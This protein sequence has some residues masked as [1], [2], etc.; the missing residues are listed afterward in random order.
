MKK[1]SFCCNAPLVDGVQ[2][3][4]CGADGRMTSSGIT[5]AKI[6][7]LV[8]QFEDFKEGEF[9]SLNEIIRFSS[10]NYDELGFQF[11]WV[12]DAGL[13]A[14]AFGNSSD[15]LKSGAIVFDWDVKFEE[16]NYFSQEELVDF[17]YGYSIDADYYNSLKVKK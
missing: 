7:E 5:K 4:S 6:A 14:I 3:E 15:A 16:K 13:W 2:C 11:Y 10:E 9:V 17:L 8:A 12:D 1:K